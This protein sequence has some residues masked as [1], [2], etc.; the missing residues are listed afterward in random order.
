MRAE[1]RINP[2]GPWRR[3]TFKVTSLTAGA[4]MEREMLA[5][6]ARDVVIEGGFERSQ[7]R[8]DGWP[9]G[10]CSPLWPD[11]RLWMECKHG[12]LKYECGAFDHW[13][14]NLRAIVL[15]MQRQRLAIE[16]WGIGSR[17]E[18]YRGFAALPPGGIAVAEW[19]SVEQAMRWLSGV[20][21]GAVL[22]TLPADLPAVYRAAAKAAH[23][24]AGGSHDL[25]TKVNRAKVFVESGGRA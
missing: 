15:W 21:N 8:N 3:A 14:A 2:L 6:E 4:D 9:R 24:D 13:E 25:M 20:G 22:S 19:T 1:S 23:P 7:I 12:S 5:I 11:I 17:G 16:E 18:A 10:G